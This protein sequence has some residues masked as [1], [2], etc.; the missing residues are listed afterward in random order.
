[1][2]LNAFY[3]QLIRATQLYT[4]INLQLIPW[5]L[6][7]CNEDDKERLTIPFAICGF[8]QLL[9]VILMLIIFFLLKNIKTI[10]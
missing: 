4:T 6:T 8:T 3:N 1:M 9:A 10:Q 2:Q 7:T 5:G